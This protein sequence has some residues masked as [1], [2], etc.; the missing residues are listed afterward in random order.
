MEQ[1][2]AVRPKLIKEEEYVFVLQWLHR[3]IISVFSFKVE[4]ERK[5]LVP[6]PFNI[7][8]LKQYVMGALPDAIE[9]SSRHLR[10]PTGGS[11]SNWLV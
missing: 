6:P 9:K 8:N 2:L 4:R 3:K 10:D 11:Y 5:I 1:F 7:S